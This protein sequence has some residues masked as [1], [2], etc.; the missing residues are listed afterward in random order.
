[1]RRDLLFLL[2]AV[3]ACGDDPITECQP[4][5]YGLEFCPAERETAIGGSCDSPGQ[6]CGSDCCASPQI[7][8]AAG[9]W[10]AVEGVPEECVGVLCDTPTS[11]GA[12]DCSGDE[13]CVVT[14]TPRGGTPTP[15]RCVR[16]RSPI[17]SCGDTPTGSIVDV[18]CDQCSCSETDGVVRISLI[19]AC[20]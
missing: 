11:C 20:C 13:I 14:G 8:C 9:V 7:E 6:L 4:Y 10:R 3:F 5:W 15:S 1:M 16:P 19:C 2:L 12:G 17:T 18:D